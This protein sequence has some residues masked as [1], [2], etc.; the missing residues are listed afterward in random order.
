LETALR[1]EEIGTGVL[2]CT[3]GQL[4]PGVVETAVVDEESTAT[5]SE[6]DGTAIVSRRIFEDAIG[7]S[8]AGCRRGKHQLLGECVRARG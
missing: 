4:S 7:D 5:G 3:A 2:N 6:V 8:D 1:E